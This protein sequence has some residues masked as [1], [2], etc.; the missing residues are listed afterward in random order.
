MPMINSTT[1]Q[2]AVATAIG[3]WLASNWDPDLTVGEWWEVLGTS[4]WAAPTWPAESFGHG[5]SRAEAAVVQR[6]IVDAG[7]LGPPGGFG[8]LLAGPTLLAHGDEGIRARHLS[9]IVTGRA[10]WC[11]LFSEPEAGSD[12]ASL[13]T[14]ALPAGDGWSIEGQKVWASGGQHAD[15]G[16]L[17]A[18]TDA[19]AAKRAGITCFVLN[20]HQSGVEVRP[21]REMTGRSLFSEVFLTGARVG[22]DAVIGGVNDGWTVARTT[23]EFE[24]AGLGSGGGA[25]VTAPV[26]PGSVAGSLSLRAGDVAGMAANKRMGS[27][28]SIFNGGEQLLI[29]MARANGAWNDAVVRND[30]MRLATFN[31]LLVAL[32]RRH[33]ELRREGKPIPGYGSIAKLFANRMLRHFQTVG[34]RVAG[35]SATLHS[36]TPEERAQLE[37]VGARTAG[38]ITGLLLFSPAPSIYGG[39]DEVQKNI[40][41]ERV[42]GLPREP[43]PPA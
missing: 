32:A 34:P 26:P 37:S 15:Y 8:L 7:A 36:Y 20:M 9:D 38:D 2:E 10:A 18:R 30:L 31:A 28:A 16:L 25:G 21:L 23:L 39:T 43:E 27:G 24:R 13:R 35:G 42:L 11:Q 29:S 40:L 41:G 14:R 3:D 19:D 33:G 6:A 1:G 4:G 17:L 22:P 12:L 5:L